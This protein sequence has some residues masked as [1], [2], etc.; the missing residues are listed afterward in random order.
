MELLVLAALVSAALVGWWHWEN[1][2]KR[3]QLDEFGIEKV[4]R[5]LKFEP[6][7]EREQILDRGWMT[8]DQW[9]DINKRQAE[10]IAA[11]LLRRGLK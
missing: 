1:H 11:E 3:R 4:H 9:I 5:V 2:V 7:K 10:S 6:E 8:R